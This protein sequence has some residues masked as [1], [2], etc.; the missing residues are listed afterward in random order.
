MKIK[1]TFILFGL[2]I[3]FI[4]IADN[5]VKIDLKK[6]WEI[7]EDQVPFNSITSMC[8]DDKQNI[9]VLD[10]M[11]FKIYKCSAKGKLLLSFGNRTINRIEIKL[12]EAA[13]MYVVFK[14]KKS[15]STPIKSIATALKTKFI[16]INIL[17][18]I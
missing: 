7:N 10:R 1:L 8:E 2:I 16:V 11:A 17:E 15:P 5:A 6:S 13:T 14:P 4:L 18:V 3:S 12:T 9:Y